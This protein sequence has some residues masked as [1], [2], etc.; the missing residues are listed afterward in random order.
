M[1]HRLLIPTAI[2][3][4]L[5][6]FP[7][8]SAAAA[9]PD[10]SEILNAAGVH[11]GLVVVAGCGDPALLAGLRRDHAFVVVGLDRQPPTIATARE[12]LR[13]QGL[14]GPVTVMRWDGKTLPFADNLVN[15]VVIY[16]ADEG[17]RAEELT[18]ALTPGGV[19]VVVYPG[20]KE[21]A[22]RLVK[23][24]PAELDG[25][26]HVFHDAS[27]NAWSRDT[28]VGPPRA[29]QWWAGPYSERSHNWVNGT[30]A[31]VSSGGRLFYLHDEGPIAVMS[32]KKGDMNWAV[33]R[34]KTPDFPEAWALV[35]RDALNGALLWKRPLEGFGNLKFEA[36]GPGQPTV[37]NCWSA[38]LSLNRRVVVSPTRVYVTLAYRGGL[39]ALSAATGETVWEY[40]PDGHVDEVIL[41]EARVFLR[42]RREIPRKLDFPFSRQTRD[43]RW[44]KT[45][46]PED[47]TKYVEQ[48]RP[49][50][51]AALDARTGRE[52]WTV[53]SRHVAPETLCSLHG[54]VCYFDYRDVVCLDAGSGRE[55]WRKAGERRLAHSGTYSRS[56]MA[57]ML[58]L[59]DGKAYFVGGDGTHCLGLADGREIW[60]G[61]R[62]GYGGGFGHPTGLRI[63]NGV[64]YDDNGSRWDAET[65]ERL[66]PLVEELALGRTH[67]RCHR[68][69]ATD[70]YLLGTRF[71]VEF[72]DIEAGKMISDHRWLRSSCA[73]GYVPANG[74]LYH[75]PDPCACWIG[76]R[77]RGYHAFA[78]K[79]PETDDDRADGKTRP[80]PGPAYEGRAQDAE[81]RT[82]APG[83][84]P[85]YRH[86]ARRSGQASTA[87]P[88]ELRPLWTAQLES[89]YAPAMF[90]YGAVRG[91][92]PPVVAAG[93]VFISR[94]DAN[95]IVCLD[96]DTGD[97]VWRY[98]TPCFVDT[99]PTIVPGAPEA[100]PETTLC[101]FG[102]ADGHVYCLRAADGVL[103]W[104]FRAT[105][106]DRLILHDGRPASKWPSHGA[107]LVRDGHVYCTA[108]RS[109]FLD[110]GIHVYKLDVATGE[111]LGHARLDGPHY[112][113]YEQNPF[114]EVTTNQWNRVE[115][116][117]KGY[118]PSY[119]DIE[120]AR[121]D[122]LVSDGVDLHMGQTRIT[123]ELETS[124]SLVE[125]AAG[126]LTGRRWLRPM[127]GFLDDTYFHRVGWHYSDRY[128]GG[129]N[130][131]GAASA[132]KLVVFDDAFAYGLQWEGEA[133]GR[134]P[135]HLI[136]N[137]TRL[138]AD[139]LR[140]PITPDRIG[141]AHLALFVHQL[142][143]AA[144]FIQ[145][146]ADPLPVGLDPRAGERVGRAQQVLPVGAEAGQV[147][148]RAPVRRF[149]DKVAQ[150]PAQ[151]NVEDHRAGAAVGRAIDV[152]SGRQVLAV[153][154]DADVPV[155]GFRVHAGSA[156][157]HC[158]LEHP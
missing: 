73:L 144:F 104:R 6:S 57:G 30:A 1:K 75:T 41:Q 4:V 32:H 89:P 26:S 123:T 146:L 35:A 58:F 131:A 90:G 38:P 129:G 25:W 8:G 74:L 152:E 7:S 27:N 46:G 110:G 54:K 96:A 119:C 148:D 42:V 11:G 92:T 56:G 138:V 16:G 158:A 72:L 151:I 102:C 91:L 53:S 116:T 111:M 36:I 101:V 84:W 47:Y 20:S 37:W 149:H 139:H 106:G 141:H 105:P 19:A 45:Y 69:V 83:D 14:Y 70:R 155:A 93:R 132:G 64:I 78:A 125:A 65:G 153:V 62:V 112:G 81:C 109:S 140:R 68:G 59:W 87:V 10:A 107:V 43:L 143:G 130:A 40:T 118:F 136:G 21:I 48:Q 135:N 61:D 50:T 15:L 103:V 108:G 88:T 121:S 94:K 34:A 137:G 147:P 5:V 124:S 99:P 28:V 17:I 51:V 85:T 76:A 97:V 100:R 71:G 49:E 67:G 13:G 145:R 150:L 18:R 115:K 12:Y 63:V 29:L 142:R 120:G 117:P 113:L 128:Y 80:E 77:M 134:Y 82:P 79:A 126:K 122:I 52:L 154:T 86:D 39:S 156:V 60:H 9:S 23:P 33:A 157:G 114:Y 133:R 24:V 31:L 98:A 66:G 95:E 2:L 22:T 3:L 44:A 55:T 127:N